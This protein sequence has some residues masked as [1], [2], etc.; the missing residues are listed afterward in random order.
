MIAP[1]FLSTVA[2]PT[3]LDWRFSFYQALTGKYID[4][5]PLESV[6]FDWGMPPTQG[7]FT[8]KLMLGDNVVNNRNWQ[9][10]VRVRQNLIHIWCNGILLPPCYF[11]W[12]SDYDPSTRTL[13]LSATE[14]WSYYHHRTVD[15]DRSFTQVEQLNIFRTLFLDATNITQTP[16]GKALPAGCGNLGVDLG[17]DVT[18]VLR[19][20][21]YVANEGKDL[22]SMLEELSAVIDGFDFVL[23]S[24]QKSDATPGRR[25][26]FGYPRLGQVAP[27]GIQ[28][29]YIEGG[30]GNIVTY[31]WPMQGSNAY[32]DRS[33]LGDNSTRA[34]SINLT[35][36]QGGM[37]L[38]SHSIV[39]TGVSVATT[40]Q[41]HADA[42]LAVSQDAQALPSVTVRLDELPALGSYSLGDDVLLYMDDYARFPNPGDSFDGLDH[43]MKSWFRLVDIKIRVADTQAD[44]T[45]NSANV[46]ATRVAS[47]NQSVTT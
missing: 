39:Y 28:F 13:T 47:A 16:D 18:G 43:R 15:V 9:A 17:Q 1:Q 36:L 21:T 20:R 24:Y 33:A 37:P 22:A 34:D 7:S 41:S 31:D 3:G 11:L 5:L 29:S 8:G 26:R 30:G 46:A 40:L 23:E 10:A 38:L 32:N 42:D 35:Q 19:D 2:G 27:S 45:F 4:S 25:I 14:L 44:L 6:E 12:D